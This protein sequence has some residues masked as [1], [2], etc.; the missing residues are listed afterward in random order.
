MILAAFI[1]FGFLWPT[2][3]TLSTLER[4]VEVVQPVTKRHEISPVTCHAATVRSNE[5]SELWYFV[6]RLKEK[7]I[8]EEKGN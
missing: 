4:R 7:L 6:N 5:S 1:S 8:E 3:K 2:L